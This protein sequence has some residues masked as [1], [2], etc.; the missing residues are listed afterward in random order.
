MKKISLVII[1][2]IVGLSLFADGLNQDAQ[3]LKDEYPAFYEAVKQ[4]AVGEWGDDHT[5]ILYVI[6]QQSTALFDCNELLSTHGIIVG[7]Q[8]AEWCD[9]EINYYENYF[10]APVDWEMVLYTSKMQI[11]AQANY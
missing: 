5:M 10:L 11:E 8:I 6:N 3:Q 2:L 7:T 4:R 1:I 9:D